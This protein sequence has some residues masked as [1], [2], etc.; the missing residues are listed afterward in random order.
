MIALKAYIKNG[1]KSEVARKSPITRRTLQKILSGQ[2]M[3]KI[4][5]LFMILDALDIKDP[6]QVLNIF[7]GYRDYN[8]GERPIIATVA[9]NAAYRKSVYRL[10]NQL[11]KELSDFKVLFIHDGNYDI[12]DF[13]FA[14]PFQGFGALK[15]EYVS[16]EEDF[17]G[18]DTSRDFIAKHLKRKVFLNIDRLCVGYSQYSSMKVHDICFGENTQT[19]DL[20]YNYETNDKQTEECNKIENGLQL[21]GEILSEFS[22]YDFVVICSIDKS[23][24]IIDCF[25]DHSDCEIYLNDD[26]NYFLTSK[27]DVNFQRRIYK[28]P[29]KYFGA[30]IRDIDLCYDYCKGYDEMME[31]EDVFINESSKWLIEKRNNVGD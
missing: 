19:L 29:K 8:Q 13:E 5:T 12:A 9:T 6:H 3:P 7:E 14:I 28:L 17:F 31:I 27:S 21:A 24:R 16:F 25:R 30:V 26:S 11:V 1:Q 2:S 10:S 15:D 4:D 18:E 22:S 23:N 20:S